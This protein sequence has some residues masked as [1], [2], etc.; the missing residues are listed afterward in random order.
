MQVQ[1]ATYIEKLKGEQTRMYSALKIIIP[2]FNE[3]QIIA[4]NF[5]TNGLIEEFKLRVKPPLL[6]YLRKNLNNDL[7]EINE[8]L[9]EVDELE[10]PKLYSDNERLQHMIE[11]N[12]ALQKL[13]SKFNLDF[14]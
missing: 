12:P 10:K 11:K 6:S 9:T 2:R 14:D 13:K 1:F 8:I 4:L 5:Q 7:I 3:G